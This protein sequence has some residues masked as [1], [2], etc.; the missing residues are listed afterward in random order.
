[1]NFGI[2]SHITLTLLFTGPAILLLWAFGFPILK[3]F[4]KLILICSLLVGVSYG[5]VVD[6]VA[7]PLGLWSFNPSKI[8]GVGLGYIPVDQMVWSFFV[9]FTMASFIVL[10]ARLEEMGSRSRKGNA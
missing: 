7:I 5:L 10:G 2:Y 9:T 3:S 4:F 6:S 1:M 8:L